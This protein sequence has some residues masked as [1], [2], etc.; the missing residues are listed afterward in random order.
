MQGGG[1]CSSP[2]LTYRTGPVVLETVSRVVDGDTTNRRLA[3]ALRFGIE[4]DT[5]FYSVTTSTDG[6][7]GLLRSDRLSSGG[8]R[9]IIYVN[10]PMA[11]INQGLYGENRVTVELRGQRATIS[12]NGVKA[13]TWQLLTVPAP[14]VMLGNGNASTVVLSRLRIQSLAP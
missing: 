5:A 4:G 11:A 7:L 6:N 9:S 12:V 8:E 3:A 1:E 13:G 2:I 10:R 14:N